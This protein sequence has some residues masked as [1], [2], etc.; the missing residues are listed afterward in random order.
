MRRVAGRSTV[1]SSSFLDCRP[2]NT[3]PKIV[4]LVKGITRNGDRAVMVRRGEVFWS[5]V[6][7]KM[8]AILRFSISGL[9]S[10][11]H[12]KC[13]EFH[14]GTANLVAG[15]EPPGNA[16]QYSHRTSPRP[17]EVA[18]VARARGGPL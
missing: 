3:I 1:K 15:E 5:V 6:R 2:I 4:V 14:R 11:S 18:I 17:V 12:P 16:I 8:S 13:A 9:V 7:D 10:G